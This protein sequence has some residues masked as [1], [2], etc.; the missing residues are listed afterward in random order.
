VRHFKEPKPMREVSLVIHRSF[1]KRK[2]IELLKEE[3]LSNIP[4]TLKDENRGRLIHWV[5]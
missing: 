4:Q 1:M 2:L 5:S 3:I